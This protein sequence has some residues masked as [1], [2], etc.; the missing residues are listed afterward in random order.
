MFGNLLNVGE[1]IL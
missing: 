1:M